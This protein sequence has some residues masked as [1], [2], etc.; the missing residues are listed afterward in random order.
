MG[1]TNCKSMLKSNCKNAIFFANVFL[2]YFFFLNFKLQYNFILDRIS[3]NCIIIGWSK[4]LQTIRFSVVRIEFIKMVG[5]RFS[6]RF[7]FG[8]HHTH[9]GIAI[10]MNTTVFF[11]LLQ[12]VGKFN[13]FF[14]SISVIMDNNN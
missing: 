7:F 3:Y 1:K 4:G 6:I 8:S 14:L 11:F 9:L 5:Y 10:H 12:E 2:S 13:F